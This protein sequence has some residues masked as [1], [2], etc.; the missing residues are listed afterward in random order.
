MK[1]KSKMARCNLWL[2]RTLHKVH[3]CKSLIS[4]L[5]LVSHQRDEVLL[6]DLI[7]CFVIAVWLF[8]VPPLGRMSDWTCSSPESSLIAWR[9]GA[10]KKIC[11]IYTFCLKLQNFFFLIAAICVSAQAA[12]ADDPADVS[13][14]LNS[15]AGPVHGE[16]LHHAGSVLLLHP[17]EFRLSACGELWRVCGLSHKLKSYWTRICWYRFICIWR[18]LYIYSTALQFLL[19]AI[20]TC[21][22]FFVEMM[23]LGNK[24]ARNPVYL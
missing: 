2:T 20:P 1:R 19:Q 13:G 5:Q 14:L 17:G 7:V 22:S 15:E 4:V 9:Y 18:T 8:F 11:F 3:T 10:R 16:V 6:H 21:Y 23:L 12:A 24:S